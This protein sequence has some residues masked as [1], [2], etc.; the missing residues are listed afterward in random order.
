MGLIRWDN[1]YI[2]MT[3]YT[4]EAYTKQTFHQIYASLL[5]AED[6]RKLGHRTLIVS[7]LALIVSLVSLSLTYFH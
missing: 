3:A 5:T 2:R 1:G 4:I 6:S 7:A